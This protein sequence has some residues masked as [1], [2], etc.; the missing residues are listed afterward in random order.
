MAQY[1]LMFDVSPLD[2][3]AVERIYASYDALVASHGDGTTLTITAEGRTASLAAKRIVEQLEGL[4]GLEVSRLVEDLV[5]KTDIA[6]RCEATTQAVGQWIRGVR[7]RNQPFPPR[8]N[9]VGG[10][11]WLWGEVNDWLRRVNRSQDDILYPC[12]RDYDEV[13]AWLLERDVRKKLTSI[14]ATV[15]YGGSRAKG[16]PAAQAAGQSSSL[17]FNIT[18]V[19]PRV[20]VRRGVSK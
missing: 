16:R 3:D 11:V 1:E 8:F 13:N 12:R 5:S 6:S 9:R 19:H 18:R 14:S 10:G 2:D 15:R 7:H 20:V 4:V 17:R